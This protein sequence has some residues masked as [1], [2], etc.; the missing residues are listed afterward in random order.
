MCEQSASI[1]EL[2]TALAKAQSVMEGAKKDSSNPHFKSKYADL[3]SVWDA[4]RKPLTDNGL[5]VVQI[6][7]ELNER[8]IMRL[9]TILIHSSGEFIGGIIEIPISKADAQGI[10]SAITYARR[11]ALAAIVG[12]SPEEDDGEGA[13]G[14][15]TK[16]QQTSSQQTP[17]SPPADSDMVTKLRNG[18]LDLAK[19]DE[20]EAAAILTELSS[21]EKDGKKYSIKW[22][23]MEKASPKW[24]ASTYSRVKEK[25][26][27]QAAAPPATDDDIPF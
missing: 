16:Q 8:N 6:P 18:L 12:I 1:K 4:A 13:V 25:L 9:K 15:G 24:I 7:M 5:A 17:P 20:E 14:R 2:A 3:E 10:G 26:A 27:E 11:Y 21:F 22:A 23:Q 19:G